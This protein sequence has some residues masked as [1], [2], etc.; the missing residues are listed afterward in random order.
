LAPIAGG[1]T[2]PN[3]VSLERL[4][5]QNV[6][7][8]VV[9]GDA[10][11]IAPVEASRNMVVQLKKLGVNHEYV[12]VAGAGHGDVVVPNLSRIVDF[13]SKQARTP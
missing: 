13:F 12:E 3:D 2:N 4:K 6:P 7:V 9:H 11:R 5:E 1:S 10:D 8:M